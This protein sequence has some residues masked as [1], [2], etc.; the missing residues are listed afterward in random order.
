MTKK[1]VK[2]FCRNRHFDEIFLFINSRKLNVIADFKPV[3]IKMADDPDQD[4]LTMMNMRITKGRGL[5]TCK[6]LMMTSGANE[7]QVGKVDMV[8]TD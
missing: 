4:R 3:D 6:R 2:L 1:I 5:C 8:T 7:V